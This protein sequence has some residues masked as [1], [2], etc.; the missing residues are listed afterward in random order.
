M[1]WQDAEHTLALGLRAAYL[2][3]KT[4]PWGSIREHFDELEAKVLRPSLSWTNVVSPRLKLHMFWGKGISRI[5][6]TLSEKGRRRLWEGKHPGS[7]YDA[8]NPQTQ[9]PTTTAPA[10]GTAPAPT[11]A[12]ASSDPTN[13]ERTATET[14]DVTAQSLQVQ[15]ITGL[16]QDRFQ[17]TGEFNRASGNKILI[18]TRIEQTEIEDLKSSGFRITAAHQ[19]IWPTFQLRI[20][21]GLQ[22]FV[23]SGRDLDGEQIDEADWQPASDLGFYWR[24]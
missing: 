13:Q 10:D 16:A 17:L 22:Y 24:F 23:I 8:R 15:S 5:R 18:T 2:S 11:P 20:G 12:A 4:M 6:A 19:W 1:V 7:D 21:A 14:S 9:E 3:K